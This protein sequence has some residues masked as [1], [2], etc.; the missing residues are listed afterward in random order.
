MSVLQHTIGVSVPVEVKALSKRH[1]YDASGA[2]EKYS[3][4]DVMDAFTSLS[5]QSYNLGAAL[6]G[7]YLAAKDAAIAAVEATR[8]NDEY[9]VAEWRRAA[10]WIRSVRKTAKGVKLIGDD[11]HASDHFRLH[12]TTPKGEAP[13]GASVPV[14][15]IVEA[16]QFTAE[17][18]AAY[19]EFNKA[20]GDAGL[21]FKDTVLEYIMTQVSGLPGTGF[22]GTVLYGNAKEKVAELT[23]KYH[24]AGDVIPRIVLPQWMLESVNQ[25]MLDHPFPQYT[26][27]GLLV[28]IDGVLIPVPRRVAVQETK[29]VAK[30]IKKHYGRNFE[31]GNVKQGAPRFRRWFDD[32]TFSF[33]TSLSGTGIFLV[34]K[35]AAKMAKEESGRNAAILHNL[36]SSSRIATNTTLGNIRVSKREFLRLR[37]L[38]AT[39]SVVDGT[40]HFAKMGSDIRFTKR[41]SKWFVSTSITMPVGWSKERPDSYGKPQ[42][43]N[44]DVPEFG[45]AVGVDVGSIETAILSGGLHMSNI[46]RPAGHADKKTYH[47]GVLSAKDEAFLAA[48]R[49]EDAS[50]E[51]IKALEKQLLIQ[52]RKLAR[53]REVAIAANDGVRKGAPMSNRYAVTKANIARIH[54]SIADKRKHHRNV[55]SKLIAGSYDLVVVETLQSANLISKNA[56]IPLEDGSFAPNGQ[57]AKRAANRQ[58][59]GA[60]MGEVLRLVKTKAG[61]YGTNVVE[62]GKT[63][64]SSQLCHC[65]GT[66]TKVGSSRVFTCSNQACGYVGDRD[67]NAAQNILTEGVRMWREAYLANSEI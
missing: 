25:Q 5:R 12:R 27:S 33:K 66:R 32:Q 62:I 3:Q 63:F 47:E 46:S 28:E 56:A 6:Y 49:Y 26:K 44:P 18:D 2:I 65:C 15:T 51:N 38:M 11:A 64:P 55:I 4:I 48:L 61:L 30:A 34:Q 22:N 54:G 13:V 19:S 20:Y 24:N 35:N 37:D 17:C 31:G 10:A 42:H 29:E 16:V 60:A 45:S 57:A 1:Q 7:D 40:R 36:A 8:S 59:S 50:Y 53:Q 39:E 52:E 21:I 41:G 43:D 58:N 9:V 23:N 14:I 67:L